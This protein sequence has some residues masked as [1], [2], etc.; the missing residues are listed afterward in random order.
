MV[1]R[2]IAIADVDGDGR[3]DFVAANQWG[4][5]YFFK[6]ESPSSNAFLGLR[7][8]HANGAPAIGASAHVNFRMVAS[9]WRKLMAATAIPGG[10]IRD[11]FR[12]GQL[13]KEQ[14]V[15]RRDQVA[16]EARKVQQKTFQMTPGWHSINLGNAGTVARST[17]GYDSRESQG[18]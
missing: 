8:V 1:G 9:L 18:L 5:S 2:G 12:P 3:L 14:A 15:A 13:G 4:P 11:S 10:A 16:R 6:N 17:S 7:L